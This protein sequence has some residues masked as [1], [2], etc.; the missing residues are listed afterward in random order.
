VNRDSRHPARRISSEL[1]VRH[2]G[3]GFALVASLI[4]AV[5]FGLAPTAL[6]IGLLAILVVD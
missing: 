4:C 3:L 1:D 2:V 5:L 6:S